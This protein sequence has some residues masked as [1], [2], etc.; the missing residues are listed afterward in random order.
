MKVL[1]WPQAT[2]ESNQGAR[3]IQA[4]WA[5]YDLYMDDM[6]QRLSH[7]WYDQYGMGEIERFM[8][9]LRGWEEWDEVDGREYE[10][11]GF[12]FSIFQENMWSRILD[13]GSDALGSEYWDSNE[14]VSVGLLSKVEGYLTGR[15]TSEVG[16]AA[17]DG[18]WKIR[19]WHMDPTFD[20]EVRKF[21]KGFLA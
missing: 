18:E 1:N 9:L 13:T 8:G 2:L 14:V 6:G 11:W 17:W 16:N 12:Q 19:F 15:L 3:L 5:D 21:G 7:K 4:S 20:I 10:D